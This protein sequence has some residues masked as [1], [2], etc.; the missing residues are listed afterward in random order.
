MVLPRVP[1]QLKIKAHYEYT[2][3][4]SFYSLHLAIGRAI[5]NKSWTANAQD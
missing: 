3:E 2:T 1:R 5:L 4:T